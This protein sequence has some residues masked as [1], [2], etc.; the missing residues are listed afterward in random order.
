[1][2]P[3]EW[4]APQPRAQILSLP[5]YR[6]VEVRP[7]DQDAAEL[8]TV[9]PSVDTQSIPS[10]AWEG[11][12]SNRRGRANREVDVVGAHPSPGERDASAHCRKFDDFVV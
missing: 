11:E 1:M 2:S 6:E 10:P 12:A 5:G 7:P 4:K 3:I 9:T 8:A